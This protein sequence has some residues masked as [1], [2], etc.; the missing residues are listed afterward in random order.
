MSSGVMIGADF[1][2]TDQDGAPLT[3]ESLLGRDTVIAAFHTTCHETCPLYTGLMFELRKNAP[4]ARLLEVTTDPAT[5]TP[6]VMAAYRQ[7][8]GADWT[9]ATGSLDAITEFGDST[10]DFVSGR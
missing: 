2:L 4:E 5:D 10:G 6:A 3:R 9:F 1:K 7:R 8:I